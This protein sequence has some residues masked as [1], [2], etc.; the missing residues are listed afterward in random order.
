MRVA[1]S[2]LREIQKQNYIPAGKDYGLGN[3]EFENFISFLENKSLLE[4]VLRIG[5][6]FSLRPARIT[7]KGVH[8]LQALSEYE[9]EYPIDRS[10]LIDWVKVEKDLYSN[11]ATDD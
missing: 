3:R 7:Q 11:S 6:T 4:R 9:L 10:G 8:F 2:V 5:D 1:Y